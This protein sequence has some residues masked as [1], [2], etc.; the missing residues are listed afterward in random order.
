MGFPKRFMPSRIVLKHR[1]PG[2]SDAVFMTSRDGLRF[3]RWGE[4]I[5]R[6]GLQKERWGNRNNMI[7]WG[8]LETRSDI[9]GTP[10]ELSLYSMEGYYQGESCQMRR[11]TLRIDGFVS[12]QAPL[13]GGEVVTRPIVFQGKELVINFSTSAAGSVQIEI[14]NAEGKPIEGFSLED[15]E[16]IYGD[17]LERVVTWKSGSDVSKLAGKPSRLRFVIKDADIYSLQFR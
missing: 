10:N 9:P 1:Y 8:I 7:A 4:A 13:S 6:P 12:V 2:V 5:I 11:F 3:K 14:Q 16:E 17:E 15:S